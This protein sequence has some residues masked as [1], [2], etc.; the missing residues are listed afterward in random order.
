MNAA[1]LWMKLERYR[2]DAEVPLIFKFST[3]IIWLEQQ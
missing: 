1:F 3:D 2:K